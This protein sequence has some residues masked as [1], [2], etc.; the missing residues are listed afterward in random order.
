MSRKQR[1]ANRRNAK[2]STGPKTAEGKQASRF[3]SVLHGLYSTVLVLNLE[4]KQLYNALYVDFRQRFRP[5]DAFELDLVERLVCCSWHMR[6]ITGIES[7]V[8]HIGH[9]RSGGAWV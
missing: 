9:P 8:L 5:V 2:K 6:R 3:N 4:D 7:G 1:A